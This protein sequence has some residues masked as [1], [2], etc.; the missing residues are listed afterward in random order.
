MKKGSTWWAKIGDSTSSPHRPTTM[1]GT[2]AMRS[3]S[4]DSG[5]ASHV[6]ASS[7]RKAAVATPMGTARMMATAVV[8]SVPMMKIPVG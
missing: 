4:T 7:E 1:L 3:M 8:M 5:D 6:G 2:A